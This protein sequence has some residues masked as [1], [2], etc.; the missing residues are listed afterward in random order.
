MKLPTA[1]LFVSIVGPAAPAQTLQPHVLHHFV[2]AAN[3]IAP[4][5]EGP[6]GNFYGTTQTD[7]NAGR[8]TVFRMTP[9]GTVSTLVN[10]TGLNGHAPWTVGLT[11]DRD[12]NLNG[13]TEYGG[14]GGR[15]TVFKVT[16]TGTLT[17]LVN[18]NNTNGS[19]P[20]GLT[21]GSDGNLYGTTVTSTSGQGTVFKVATDG[22][23]T[24]L[25]SFPANYYSYP[26]D[27]TPGRDG[28]LYGRTYNGFNGYG[29]VFRVTTNGT[30]TMLA[31][32]SGSPHT[33]STALT[34]GNDGN[35]YGTTLEGGSSRLGTAF[36]VTPEG[37]LTTLVNFN[38]SNGSLPAG[39]LTLGSDGSFYGTTVY[40]GLF[41]GTVFKMTPDG[42][43]T[44]LAHFTSR[45][46][47]V[48]PYAGVTFGADGS[49][50]GT[51]LTGGSRD[52]G[53]FFRLDLPPTIISQPASRTNGV[54]S[55]ATFT[56]TATGTRPFSYQW[57]RNGM[58]LEDGGNVSGASTAMLTLANV[59]ATDAGDFAVVV[60]NNSG[61]VTSSAAALAV[62][63]P[64]T[65][66]DGVLDDQD[67]CPG[68]APGAIVDGHGCSIE[69]LVPCAGPR[70]GARWKNHG[71]YVSAVMKLV[72]HFL[73]Q[74]VISEREAKGIVAAAAKSNC[75]RR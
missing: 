41:E 53:V 11:L 40:G 50:Y 6:D 74:G 29:T 31:T 24:T 63:L 13:T 73:A 72:R 67:Q 21:T 27:L 20:R 28:S 1:L 30:L 52:G 56:V 49:L 7:G 33:Y 5:V 15:G 70:P 2:G 61:S 8:G 47:G 18:F 60:A 34:L 51:T 17:T 19:S 66:G 23:F 22:T 9:A 45:A 38:G 48:R 35:F 59:Q 69:Q 10:F 58:D 3:P 44:T 36:Q 37:Q 43:L 46:S 42:T 71:E 65:D 54:G 16:L 62:V 39:P 64:D 55:T 26:G 14:S 57:L 75:G 68:T 4:V 32:L 25:V 12:G